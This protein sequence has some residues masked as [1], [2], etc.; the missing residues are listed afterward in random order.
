MKERN[1]VKKKALLFHSQQASSMEGGQLSHAS[2]LCLSWGKPGPSEFG[3]EM[4]LHGCLLVLRRWPGSLSHL[5]LLNL[6]LVIFFFQCP[7]LC[8]EGVGNFIEQCW[9]EDTSRQRQPL[10]LPV[11]HAPNSLSRKGVPSF[12]LWAPSME[13]WLWLNFPF[14]AS[15]CLGNYGRMYLMSS[16]LPKAI[17]ADLL[18]SS[19]I[20]GPVVGTD[21][22]VLC[23]GRSWPEYTCQVYT[24]CYFLWAPQLNQW[25]SYRPTNLTLKSRGRNLFITFPASE[26][27]HST[28]QSIHLYFSIFLN[29]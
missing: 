6:M 17:P 7:R 4:F 25:L 20:T 27:T 19:G 11:G 9:A 12:H 16:L 15:G 5:V 22:D 18:P 13:S 24:L 29:R 8:I 28:G 3:T 10:I 26:V 14:S 1:E 2:P 21:S 23:T